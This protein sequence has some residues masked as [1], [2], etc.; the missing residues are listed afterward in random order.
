MS[1]V[2]G[3]IR[4][5]QLLWSYGPGSMIDLP[6]LSVTLMGLDKWDES[7][8]SVIDE[9]RL[10]QS[11]RQRLGGQVQKLLKPPVIEDEKVN[12]GDPEF[13]S[14]VP[15][16]PFPG[17]LRCVRCGLLAET[18]TGQFTLKD[19]GRGFRPDRIHW[20]HE[21]CPKAAGGNSD[22]VPARFL[23][24]C[25]NG[26]LDDFPW[27][28]FVHGGPSTCTGKLYFY[29]R[30]ASLQTENL[31]VKCEGCGSAR[32]LVHAFGEEAKKHLP[33]CRGRHP[34]LG[35]HFEEC[36]QNARS[37][38][39]GASNSWFPTHVSVLAIPMEKDL[40]SQILLDAWEHLNAISSK[41][42]IEGVIV[43]FKAAGLYPDLVKY[44]PEEIWDAIEKK[45]S[46]VSDVVEITESDVKEPEWDVLTSPDPPS[47]W[48]FFLGEKVDVPSKY[49]NLIDEVLQL[50]RLRE[51]N[52]LIGFTRIESSDESLDPDERP[53]MG[54]LSDSLP[55]WVPAN[56][57]HGE[58]IFIKFKEDI[59]SQWEKTSGVIKRSDKMMEG[60]RGWRIARNLDPE[61][62]YPGIRYTMIHTFSHLLIREFALECGYNEASIRERVYATNSGDKPMAGVLLYTAAADSDGTLGGLV[63]LG[64][65][66]NLGPIIGQALNRAKI[67]S[68][69][70]LCSEHDPGKDRSLHL[71]A[72]HSCGFVAETSCERGNRYLD[73]GVVV[74]T[75]ECDDA[76]FF[77]TSE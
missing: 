7:R 40:L 50:K 27:H 21:N 56:E 72:C 30:G 28:W 55:E 45:R 62:G 68:S 52:A 2:V 25:R 26:H 63:E 44:T 65:P 51:V 77:K 32:S 37:I 24:A 39:L 41:E 69:D 15:V 14:G 31:M 23:V 47:D 9:A 17:W 49:K 57:V 33:K 43:G 70:P 13:Y 74:E 3:D 71:A 58:G 18:R 10:L 6:N 35:N 16:T 61:K 67:C 29:E 36:D 12:P 53:P 22:A 59:V 8:C 11:V 19:P 1:K 48:P 5:S 76:A 38:I 66:E 64:K 54:P 4:P 73:R 60:H 46:G 75:F 42:A 20:V 34:H